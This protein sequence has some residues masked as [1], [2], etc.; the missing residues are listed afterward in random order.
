MNVSTPL[1]LLVILHQML[2]RIDAFQPLEAK[3]RPAEVVLNHV[4]TLRIFATA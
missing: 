2:P 3:Y 4:K 1:S